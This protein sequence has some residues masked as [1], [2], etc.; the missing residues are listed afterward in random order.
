MT[1][2]PSRV[3]AQS[4]SNAETP[5]PSACAKPGNVFSGERPRAPRWPCSSSAH[6]A[7]FIIP[8]VSGYRAAGYESRITVSRSP[9]S[10]ARRRKRRHAPGAFRLDEAGAVLESAADLF[11]GNIP[12]TAF[13]L[14][15]DP[16]L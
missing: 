4:S 1:T 15:L 14:Y 11:L 9:I 7:G 2:T 16:K 5:M 8:P 13:Y 12:L 3:I 6:G 10:S